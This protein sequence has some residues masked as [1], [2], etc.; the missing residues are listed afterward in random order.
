MSTKKFQNFCLEVH[1]NTGRL[2]FDLQYTLAAIDVGM[3]KV[4]M[5]IDRS[6]AKGVCMFTL[7]SNI[8][9]C[10]PPPPPPPPLLAAAKSRGGI[11]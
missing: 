9:I 2:L 5:Q 10:P 8:I 4:C 1:S 11:T 3:L 7:E 6:L